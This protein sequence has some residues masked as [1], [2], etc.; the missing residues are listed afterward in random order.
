MALIV[1]PFALMGAC[2]GDDTTTGGGTSGGAGTTGSSGGSGTAGGGT[3]GEGT[4]GATGTGG[5]GS[6]GASGA[7]TGGGGSGGASTG[8]GGSGG[9]STGG[10]GS[11]G[12]STDGGSGGS[13]GDGGVP[14]CTSKMET[15]PA[16]SAADFCAILAATCKGA[17]LDAAYNTP[18]KCA[19]A[20]AA[21]TKM[22][23]QSYHLCNAVTIDA[24]MHCPHA[25]G[26]APCK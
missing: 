24:T 20:Y 1:S 9:A 12:S 16:M 5:G 6:T 10:G 25:Q 21:A 7:S 17:L 8:G 13:K 4:G 26:A 18:E 19:G 23:C 14:A 11:G 3:G 2:G 22:Q 15:S